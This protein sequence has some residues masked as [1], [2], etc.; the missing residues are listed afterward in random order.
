VARVAAAIQALDADVL[1]L[2][3]VDRGQE[4]SGGAD[5]AA[6]AAEA[7]GATDHRFAAAIRGT[8][9]G[10]WLPATGDDETDPTAYGVALLSRYAVRSWQVVRLPPLPVP[11]PWIWH[12]TRRP[13]LVRDEPRVAVVAD[14]ATPTGAMTVA[15]T[16]V[17]FLPGSNVRQ[18]RRLAA[19]LRGRVGPL[20]LMG[21]LNMSSRAAQRC[22]GLAATAVG[23]TFP[24]NEPTRQIDHI[25]ARG[26]PGPFHGA[27]RRLPV[28]DHCALI[29]DL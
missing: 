14:V 25:L 6:V 4:R 13:V 29:V 28:S 27:V 8:P 19:A 22:T 7:M 18:L 17:S 9:G 2:Q 16:H 24:A 15:T 23:L 11:A 10:A 21:D 5:L 20:L 12:G 3:E 26:V 1:A